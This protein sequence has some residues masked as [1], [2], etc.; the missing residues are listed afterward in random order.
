MATCDG[1]VTWSGVINT[2]GGI[3]TGTSAAAAWKGSG[4]TG[5]STVLQTTTTTL[6]YIRLCPLPSAAPWWGVINI[7]GGTGVITGRSVS[8]A[9]N[10]TGSVCTRSYTVLH[11]S[12]QTSTTTMTQQ[13]PDAQEFKRKY[14][15]L[16][17]S[18]SAL[19]DFCTADS[20]T[21]P[22]SQT[23][24]QI[25]PCMCRSTVLT[26]DVSKLT[27][28]HRDTDVQDYKSAEPLLRVLLILT[29]G[30]RAATTE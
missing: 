21:N 9:Q 17:C 1:G 6:N 22:L 23:L 5:S 7:G 4:C 2:G 14:C 13:C 12:T 8:A 29:C 16:R 28:K 10:I 30:W 15:L 20:W 18:W 26:G 24:Q 11:Q 25:H 19:R 27:Q 3:I